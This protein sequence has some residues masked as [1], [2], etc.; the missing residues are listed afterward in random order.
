MSETG[1]L[2]KMLA[3]QIARDSNVPEAI[4]ERAIT[5][6]INRGHLRLVRGR[7]PGSP[8]VLE[9]IVSEISR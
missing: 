8:P 9:F 5:E 6:L 2:L 4:A 1:P 3:R 7:A